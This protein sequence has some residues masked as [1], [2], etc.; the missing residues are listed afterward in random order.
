MQEVT[1][2]IAACCE[3]IQSSLAGADLVAPARQVTELQTGVPK[4]CGR[5]I[6]QVNG[7]L[8]FAAICIERVA[9]SHDLV[10]LLVDESLLRTCYGLRS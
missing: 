10:E 6:E 7:T 1:K 3:L 4:R 5:R 8:C 9:L 2:A